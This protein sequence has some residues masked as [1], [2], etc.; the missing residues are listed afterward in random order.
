MIYSKY[1]V[2]NHVYSI[3]STKLE[4]KETLSDL[5]VIFR[6][7]LNFDM[8]IDSVISRAFKR[9]YFILRKCK[10]F[11]NPQSMVALFN[12]IVKPILNY[13]SVIWC[14]HTKTN[15][16]KIESVQH[17]FM[18]CISFKTTSPMRFDQH[19]YTLIFNLL[20]MPSLMSIRQYN[21]LIYMFK[22]FNYFIDCTDL[23][24]KVSTIST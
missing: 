24:R 15:I 18:R 10:E 23:L 16:K 3:N 9:V 22:V 19:D 20:N 2:S 4:N 17:Y 7:D 14:P 5:E 13:A 1:Q 8:H 6:Y 21:D 11:T 12:S